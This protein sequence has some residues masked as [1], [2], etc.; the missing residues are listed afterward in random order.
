ESTSETASNLRSARSTSLACASVRKPWSTSHRIRSPIN[1]GVVGI[2]SRSR[3]TGPVTI[4]F[5]RSI[6][7]ELSTRI[8]EVSAL[9]GPLQMAFPVDLAHQTQDILLPLQTQQHPEPGF[10][11]RALGLQAR[12]PKGLL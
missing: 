1:S 4:L 7:T 9:P 12:D 3:R 2:S 6:H 10:H 8:T 5:R 11:H